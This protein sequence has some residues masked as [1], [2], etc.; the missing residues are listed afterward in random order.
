MSTWAAP[1][2]RSAAG[3]GNGRS[4]SRE[5]GRRMGTQEEVDEV[6]HRRGREERL[7]ENEACMRAGT[8]LISVFSWL[9]GFLINCSVFL[10][11]LCALCGESGP[12]LL[13]RRQHLHQSDVDVLTAAGVLGVH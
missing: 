13:L 9:P 2:S 3:E 7:R 6:I 12:L 4:R 1:T 5:T 10:R 8:E 11:A